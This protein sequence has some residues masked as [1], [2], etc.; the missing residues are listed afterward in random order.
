MA[1]DPEPRLNF[2]CGAVRTASGRVQVVAPHLTSHER[3]A[4]NHYGVSGIGQPYCQIVAW[5]RAASSADSPTTSPMGWWR[6]GAP[7]P[8]HQVSSDGQQVSA[9]SVC[10]ACG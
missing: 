6:G 2:E 7:P 1:S 10:F 8:L 9:C 4:S 3:F 5:A